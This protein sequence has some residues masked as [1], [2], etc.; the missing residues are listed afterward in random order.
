MSAGDRPTR[1]SISDG[2]FYWVAGACGFATGIVG[3]AFHLTVHALDLL[4]AHAR[5]RV[6]LK[7]DSERSFLFGN[8]VPKSSLARI[9]ENTKAG[10]G[11]VVMSM[12][13]VPLGFGIAA[14]SAQDCR[15][16]DTNA[17]VVLHQ[18][19]AGEYLRKE[20]ELM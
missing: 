7:P 14:R 20:E 8:S 9:T 11:V 4:A 6:W 18:A 16:A 1:P 3:G 13:D 17:V 19:D 2:L 15:K 12:A 5:R 10:D